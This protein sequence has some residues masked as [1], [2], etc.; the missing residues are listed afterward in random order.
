M[1]FSPILH[2]SMVCSLWLLFP[3]FIA[4]GSEVSYYEKC[5]EYCCCYY[6]QMFFC[7]FTTIVAFVR[8]HVN[9]TVSAIMITFLVITRGTTV[10]TYCVFAKHFFLHL[11]CVEKDYSR[12]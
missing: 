7:F 6:V 9:V 1:E 11:F 2:I 8:C 3:S 5:D 4:A 10:I 12:T